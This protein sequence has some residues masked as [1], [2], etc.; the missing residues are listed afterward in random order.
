[1]IGHKIMSLEN[2]KNLLETHYILSIVIWQFSYI[3][4][5][6]RVSFADFGNDLPLFCHFSRSFFICRCA[7][8]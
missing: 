1:M 6:Y 5:D 4:I 2:D 7:F 8:L 3:P